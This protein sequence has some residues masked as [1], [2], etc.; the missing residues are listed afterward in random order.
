VIES[1]TVAITLISTA[2]FF[3]R[4]YTGFAPAANAD[5]VSDAARTADTPTI[6]GLDSFIIPISYVEVWEKSA[7]QTGNSSHTDRKTQGKIK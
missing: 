4:K 6:T 3:D 7:V 2:A 5:V 1:P